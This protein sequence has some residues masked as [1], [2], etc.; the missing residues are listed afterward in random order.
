MDVGNLNNPNQSSGLLFEHIESDSVPYADIKLQ[1]YETKLPSERI[2]LN[3]SMFEASEN[4]L[5]NL[6]QS[7]KNYHHKLLLVNDIKDVEDED[8]LTASTSK[9]IEKLKISKKKVE[10][11]QMKGCVI[12]EMPQGSE[13]SLYLFDNWGDDQFIGINGIEILDRWGKRPTIKSVR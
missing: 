8:I 2:V 5:C 1:K 7:R 9:C 11:E 13:L 4:E 10:K 12:P 3:K 6:N